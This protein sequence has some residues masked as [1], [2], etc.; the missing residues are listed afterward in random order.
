MRTVTIFLLCS[1]CGHTLSLD[2]WLG[3]KYRSF[4]KDRRWA[5]WAMRLIQ[6]QISVV[7]LW[8]VWH[9]LNGQDWI[10]GSALYYATRMEDM[11]NFSIPLIM[12]SLVA[13]KVLTWSTLIIE[14]S[15]GVLVW[16]EKFRKPVIVAGLAFHLGIE[17]FMSIPFFEIL[18]MCLLVLYFKPE[19]LRDFV[20]RF[21]RKMASIKL[22]IR[23]PI[24]VENESA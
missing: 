9:K 16:V 23:Q 17:Y 20:Y 7:Y 19:E 15:L 21:H 2:A 6:I 5:P 1:P 12:D 18:M 22:F 13:L 14:L 11:T 8:T 3:R 4:R 10:E 24:G